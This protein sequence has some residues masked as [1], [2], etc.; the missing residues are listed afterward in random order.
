MKK[1]VT[2]EEIANVLKVPSR[3]IT[4]AAYRGIPGVEPLKLPGLNVY[5][6]SDVPLIAEA[7]KKAGHEIDDLTLLRA[8]NYAA[9]NGAS[10]YAERAAEILKECNMTFD[11]I[12]AII[13]QEPVQSHANS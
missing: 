5:Q 8:R 2:T 10:Y 6:P 1:G 7:L 11:E 3:V 4:T 9:T 13:E 12:K